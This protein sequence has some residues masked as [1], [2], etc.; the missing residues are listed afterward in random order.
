MSPQEGKTGIQGLLLK[1][2][3]YRHVPIVLKKCIKRIQVKG[4]SLA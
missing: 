1:K 3:A 2:K 4:V